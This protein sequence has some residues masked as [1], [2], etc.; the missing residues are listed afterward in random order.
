[1]VDRRSAQRKLMA[2]TS[3]R[4]VDPSLYNIYIRVNRKR[5]VFPTIILFRGGGGEKMEWNIPLL[6]NDVST[7]THHAIPAPTLFNNPKSRQDERIFY[8]REKRASQL[9]IYC[10][11]ESCRLYF[12]ALKLE[13]NIC[14]IWHFWRRDT[15]WDV[16]RKKQPDIQRCDSKFKTFYISAYAATANFHLTILIKTNDGI[17]SISEFSFLYYKRKRWTWNC[18]SSKQAGKGRHTLW[19]GFAKVSRLE[20]TWIPQSFLPN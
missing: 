8:L 2:V 9:R 18:F 7:M 5:K 11:F 4:A 16:T 17:G 3:N 12:N 13:S 6:R 1:M 19:I 10:F 14:R 15:M 20:R